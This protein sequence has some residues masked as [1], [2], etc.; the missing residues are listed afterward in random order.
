VVLEAGLGDPLTEWNR[1]QTGIEKFCRVCSYD[2]AGYGGSEEGP[3]PRT[4][5]VIARELHALLRNAGEKAPFVLVGHSFG[6]Y[7]AR[8]FQGLHPTEVTGLVLVDAPQEDQYEL[9]PSQWKTLGAAMLHRYESQAKWAPAFI[10]LGVAN[11]MLR[12]RGIP[13]S[14]L[15]LQS[16]YLRARASELRSVQVS[17]EQARAAGGMGDKP[18][19]VLTAGKADR[20]GLA[21]V[22]DRQQIEES[23]RIWVDVL[24]MRL[25]R[26]ST[27]AKQVV[28]ADSGHDIPTEDPEAVVN[29]VRDLITG[30]V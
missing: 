1:V 17:A 15:Y 16:K 13:P 23:Q 25:A 9:L 11:L 26:L 30:A 27:R 4:S 5:E 2:R 8:V 21:C 18:L 28:V 19:V 3:M 24:Q 22:L 6:G 12:W 14:H 29:A 20:A 10:N 7:N